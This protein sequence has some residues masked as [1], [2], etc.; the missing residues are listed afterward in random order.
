[1]IPGDP[2]RWLEYVWEMRLRGWPVGGPEDY[3][4]WL[5]SRRRDH[6]PGRDLAVGPISQIYVAGP[7]NGPSAWHVEQNVRAAEAR[8]LWLHEQ[9]HEI[10]CPVLVRCPHTHSRYFSGVLPESYWIESTMREMVL[11]QAIYMLA[12]WEHSEGSRRELAE[13]RKRGLVV[14]WEPAQALA[15]LRKQKEGG[16]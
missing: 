8:A 11:C 9:I 5:R 7:Y 12:G 16:T 13:A 10:G 2:S 1:V 15:W 14:V 4:R 6:E 3:D